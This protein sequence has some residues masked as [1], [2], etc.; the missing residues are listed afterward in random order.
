VSASA[1]GY[2]PPS[3]TATYDENS[4]CQP[5]NFIEQ[6]VH[7]WEAAAE[8]SSGDTRTVKLRIGVVIGKGGGIIGNM[9]FPFYLGLGGPVGNGRQWF[10]WVHVHDVAGIILHAIETPSV[11]GVLNAVAPSAN[12]NGDFAKALGAAMWRPSLLP[13]PG[14][15]VNTVFGS[16]RGSVMLEGQRVHPKRTLEAGYV[17][18]FPAM[19][20]ACEEVASWK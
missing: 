11:T 6:L 13:L 4:V 20:E 14:F 12:S 9:W 17:F 16:E 7:D 19:K 18:Q 5:S 3:P 15:V 2:Y 8:L 1:V 10:P